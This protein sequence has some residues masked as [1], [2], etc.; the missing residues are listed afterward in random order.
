MHIYV[1]LDLLIVHYGSYDEMLHQTIV[2]FAFPG[3]SSGT[4]CG[5][6]CRYQ[7]TGI[8]CKFEVYPTM[9]EENEISNLFSSRRQIFYV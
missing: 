8:G 5:A 7:A 3:S 1:Y 4:F 9:I 6:T 2:G